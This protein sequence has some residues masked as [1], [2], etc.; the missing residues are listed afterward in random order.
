[1]D[2][3][4]ATSGSGGAVAAELILQPL[5]ITGSRFSGNAALLGSGGAL[6]LSQARPPIAHK[7]RVSSRA[8]GWV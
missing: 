4:I 6:S 2:G 1:M 7:C 8:W 5:A 3:N